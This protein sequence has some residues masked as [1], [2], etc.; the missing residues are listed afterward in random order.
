LIKNAALFNTTLE[1]VSNISL[2]RKPAK[3]IGPAVKAESKCTRLVKDVDIAMTEKNRGRQLGP[4][5]VTSE[6]E[7]R[8]FI[9]RLQKLL[10]SPV[11]NN[12]WRSA[13]IKQITSMY[14]QVCFGRHRVID[15]CFEAPSE[16]LAPVVSDRAGFFG[17]RQTQMSIREENYPGLLHYKALDEIVIIYTAL[18]LYT[19]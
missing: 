4:F 10:I 7:Y 13:A 12:F 16:I 8:Q 11:N 1:P 15:D 3:R 14:Q 19:V 2:E 9:S 6:H 5:V 17:K 18:L